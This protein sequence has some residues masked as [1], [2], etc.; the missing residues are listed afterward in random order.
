[1][2]K[3]IA[4][5]K[6]KQKRLRDEIKLYADQL[7]LYGHSTQGVPIKQILD[8]WL[9]N[10]IDYVEAKAS[11]SVL[12][13]RK[14]DFIRTYQKY[15]PLGA[16]LTRIEREIKV[17]EQTY[18]ELLRSLNIA[19]M[20]QQNLEMSTNIKIV[21]P[22]Y[23]PIQANPSKAKFMV[24]AAFLAG[25]IIIAFIIVALE[26]FDT[27]M[28]NPS[29]V[30]EKTKMKLAG[31]Y[32]ALTD[33]E[34]AMALASISNRLVDMTIQ[35]IKLGLSKIEKE[36]EKP[37]I[38]LVF[39]TQN[40]TGKT[41]ISQ[42]VINRLRTIGDKVLYLNYAD[43]KEPL[44]DEDYNYSYTYRITD[45]FIDIENLGQLIGENYL[46]KVN[47]AYDYIFIE[48]PSIIYHSYPLRLLKEVHMALF[49]IKATQKITKADE[50]ALETFRES[51]DVKPLVV[52]NQ[53]DIHSLDEIITEIPKKRSSFMGKIK[54][55]LTYPGRYKIQIK[56]EA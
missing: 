34:K 8:E 31:A 26:Y 24:I 52:L 36:V 50:A 48:I 4:S 55:I 5:L 20:K 28:K 54:R 41:L 32:P 29:R 10:T 42:K 13:Q 3:E 40:K 2:A 53:V 23:F 11:L 1:V 18:L 7:Y 6:R 19:K 17:A 14:L 33:K 45:N 16:M 22:P 35:N 9:K 56:K 46:R 47:S 12:S 49:V 30:V 38:I 25:F 21:D 39:S 37:Y 51:L 15:A 43:E 27:S 44:P